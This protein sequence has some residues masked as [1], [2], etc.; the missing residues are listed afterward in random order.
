LT[1]AS[2]ATFWSAVAAA[3]AFVCHRQRSNIQKRQLRLPHSKTLAAFL[4]LSLVLGC[5]GHEQPTP[6]K[7]LTKVRTNLNPTL[8]YAP[9]MIAKDEH[10]FEDEGIDAELVRID[11]SS[12]LVALMS[13]QLDVISG[14]IRSGIFNVM[15][16]KAP[17]RVVA[18][19]GRLDPSDCAIEAFAAPVKMAER[20]EAR[21]GD[22][23]GMKFALIRGG[24]TEFMIDRFLAQRKLTRNDIEYLQIAPGDST[25][26]AKKS[27]EAI[28]YVQEPNLSNGVSKGLYKIIATAESVAPHQQHG[29]VLYGK[30]LLSDDPELGRRFMRAYLRGV[31]RYREG[32][33]RRNVEIIARHTKLP[34]E[35]IERSCWIP[36]AADGQIEMKSMNEL[37]EW[38]LVHGYL[39]ARIPLDQWW[40]PRFINAANE[41]LPQ[42]PAT[43]R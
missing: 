24:F 27:I 18:D 31:R 11:S 40:D 37:L 21:G 8:T 42:N 39:D 34:A 3:T 36:I 22:V 4:A 7:P 30:R 1:R 9:I 43:T 20:L 35:I 10:F 5:R 33:T 26:T 16:R 15:L 17:M 13:G 12:S 14:P 2:I 23:R 6:H 28:R 19:R 29:V 41:S 25:V 32:K 38:S